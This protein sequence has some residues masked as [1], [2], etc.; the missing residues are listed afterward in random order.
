MN[1]NKYYMPFPHNWLAKQCKILILKV[2]KDT[3]RICDVPNSFLYFPS[4]VVRIENQQYQYVFS[5]VINPSA[6]TEIQ[7]TLKLIL[8]IKLESDKNIY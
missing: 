4:P 1:Q 3:I 2:I 5:A 8:C 7:M 6:E